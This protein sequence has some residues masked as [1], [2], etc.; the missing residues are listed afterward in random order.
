M[1]F[2]SVSIGLELLVALVFQ[3]RRG[4]RFI[5]V[6]NL[7]SQ[8][9]MRVAYYGL[10]ALSF[11][12]LVVIIALEAI[13]FSTEFL[14]YRNS[15]ALENETRTKLLVYTIAANTLSFAV[16]AMMNGIGL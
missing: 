2:A 7:I 1:F 8:T 11:P 16:V 13:V 9:F 10:I 6:V 14:V 12:H 3:I 5:F 4:K 15:S